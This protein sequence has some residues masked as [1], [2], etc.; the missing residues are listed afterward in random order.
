MNIKLDAEKR[1]ALILSV[2]NSGGFLLV[3]FF[4]ALFYQLE[5]EINYAPLRQYEYYSLVFSVIIF[6]STYLASIIDKDKL[7]LKKEASKKAI[8]TFLSITLPSI[9][10]SFLFFGQMY[11]K[12]ITIPNIYVMGYGG[13]TGLITAYS[14]YYHHFSLDLNWV[15][16]KSIAIE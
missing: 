10:V 13:L 9:L 14:S 11:A 7:T 2:V 16:S 4:T 1:Y 8:C 12:N 6:L 15:K 3:V 5:F